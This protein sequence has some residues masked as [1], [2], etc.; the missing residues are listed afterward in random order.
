[1]LIGLVEL[2]LPRLLVYNLAKPRTQPR[3]VAD[4]L[5]V[6]SATLFKLASTDRLKTTSARDIRLYRPFGVV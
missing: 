6:E 3:N 2:D 4:F 1:L 5:V